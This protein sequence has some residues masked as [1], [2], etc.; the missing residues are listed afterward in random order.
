MIVVNPDTKTTLLCTRHYQAYNLISARKAMRFLM[1]GRGRGVDANGNLVSWLGDDI[2]LTDS[3]SLSWNK[4]NI[5]LYENQP[6][7]RSAPNVV[8]GEET[9]WAVPTILITKYAFDQKFYNTSGENVSL[10]TVYDAYKHRCVYC[11]ETIPYHRATKDHA[12]P[13]SKGGTNHDFN[14]VLACKECNNDKDDQ[15]PYFD[16]NGKEVIPLKIGRRSFIP[17]G[18]EIRAE[19]SDYLHI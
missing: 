9:Q 14:L 5:G 16:I 11:L 1:A 10:R 17:N 18:M 19:W 15:Y 4:N 6:C 8:T 12:Y 2:N 7:L 13:K 3:V